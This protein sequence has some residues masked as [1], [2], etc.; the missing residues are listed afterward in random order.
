MMISRHLPYLLDLALAVVVATSGTFWAA[1]P[2]RTAFVASRAACS[3]RWAALASLDS[4][5]AVAK[6]AARP[7]SQRLKQIYRAIP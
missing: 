7:S 6:L 2:R 5:A 1:T 4:K 3:A